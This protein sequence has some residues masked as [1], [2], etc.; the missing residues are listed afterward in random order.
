MKKKLLF[1]ISDELLDYCLANALQ[2]KY[3]A[4]YFAITEVHSGVKKF[5]DEQSF[6]KFNK[7]WHLFDHISLEEKEPDISFLQK[8]EDQYNIRIWDMAYSERL[9]YPQFNDR[10]RYSRNE[11]LSI[12]EQQCKLFLNV[13]NEVKPNYLI[14]GAVTRLPMYVIYNLAKA[15]GINILVLEPWHSLMTQCLLSNHRQKYS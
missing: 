12:I 7:I 5:L 9:F 1:W 11:I 10:Y 3:D 2:K 8:F 15:M 4:D 14:L 6:V 13:I